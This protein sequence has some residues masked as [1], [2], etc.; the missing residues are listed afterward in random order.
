MKML[1]TVVEMRHYPQLR[2]IVIL[3]IKKTRKIEK[4]RKEKKTENKKK[5]P[6][7]PLCQIVLVVYF[8]ANHL[9]QFWFS[10]FF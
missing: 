3:Q 6:I 9:L 4:K 8:F 7:Y 2:F 10:K 5:T 1:R